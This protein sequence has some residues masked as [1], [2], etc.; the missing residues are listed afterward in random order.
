MKELVRRAP[1]CTVSVS[2]MLC[3]GI[4]G[5][6]VPASGR[7][8]TTRRL[9]EFGT[10]DYSV[11]TISAASFTPG[12]DQTTTPAYYTDAG[13]LA[14]GFE[15]YGQFV[16]I[17]SGELGELY[18]TVDI[19]SGAII[20]HIGLNTTSPADAQWGVAFSQVDLSGNPNLVAAF[21]STAHNGFSTDYNPAPLSFQ[22]AQ[23]AGN[24]L[25]LNVE[26]AGSACCCPL[27][28][29]VEIWW[30]R[31][32]SPSPGTADFND[33]PTSHPFFQYIEAL[34]RA[35]ITGGCGGGNFCPDN[36]VT[37]GQLAVFLAKALGLHW[38]N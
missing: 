23:N 8:P 6:Q 35:G 30:R 33:V 11:T 7:L 17:G 37:R 20:E 16:C 4:L 38:P 22:L 27:F 19:P 18:A 29:F 21:S 28:S 12:S 25:V 1:L 14:R 31:A 15:K 34:Y 5:A 2:F 24:A 26:E 3:A 36:P 32:V 9:P 10:T 13:S